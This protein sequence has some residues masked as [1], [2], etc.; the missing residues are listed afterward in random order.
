MTPQTSVPDIDQ[1]RMAVGELEKN[2]VVLAGAG[3]GK[4]TLL[5]DRL[6]LLL[7]GKE[8]PIEK[9][10]ALTFTKKAAEEMRE[11]LE[12]RLRDIIKGE[13]DIEML[14][15][16]FLSN[17]SRWVPLAKKALEDI[18]KAQIGTIHSFAGHVLRLYPLQ[19]GVD[20]K[21]R[22]DEGLIREITFESLWKE[23]INKELDGT[24]P[25]SVEWSVLLQRVLLSDLRKLAAALVSPMIDREDLKKKV[26]LT[27]LLNHAANDLVNLRQIYPD[28]VRARS[29]LPA[30]EALGAIFDLAKEKKPIPEAL[31]DLIE[32]VDKPPVA[33]VEA[34]VKLKELKRTAQAL[35][36]LDENLFRQIYER[37]NPFIER[38]Q[39]ELARGGAVSFDGL[40]V[41][42]RN[43]LREHREVRASLKKRFS[44]F[45]VDEF[46]DTDPLQGEILFYLAEGPGKQASCWQEVQLEPGRL[47]VVGDPKQ[48]IYRFRG[49]DIAA[50]EAFEEHMVRQGALQAT[51]SA[52]FRSA[53]PIIDFV[54]TVFSPSMREEKFIQPAYTPLEPGRM[55][56]GED[57]EF[58]GPA[59]T[60]VKV[61]G[62]E[63]EKLSA[64]GR[65]IVEAQTI[66]D[67]IESHIK[68][69][70]HYGDIAILLRSANAFEEY[71]EVF[72]SRGIPY[73]AEGEKSFYRT[74]E[75]LD[76]LN[77]LS[78]VADPNDKLALVGV[79]RSPVGGLN[80]KEIWDLNQAESLSVLKNPLVHQDKIG[81]LFQTLRELHEESKS[82]PLGRT[83][84]QIFSRTWALETASTS[85]HGEQAMA[86]L[87]KVG[88]LAEKWSEQTPLTLKEFVRRFDQYRDEER[89]EGENPL[90]DVKYDA[91]KVLTI[92]K[93][94]GLEFPLV[95]LPNLSANKRA[96]NDKKDVRRDWRTGTVGL[97]L[98]GAGF[99]NA[100]MIEIERQEDKRE[101][102]EEIRVFYV[103]TTRAKKQLVCFVGGGEKESGQFA[104]ILKSAEL[105]PHFHVEEIQQKPMSEMTS[106]RSALKL[107]N[108][109]NV[110]GLSAG[111]QKRADELTRLVNERLILSPTALLEEPEKKKYLEEDETYPAREKALL[112]GQI[113][114]KVLEEWDF[115]IPPAKHKALLKKNVDRAAQLVEFP[116]GNSSSDLIKNECAEIIGGFL[117]SALYQKLCRVK[118]IGRE[119]P[120]VY[121]QG[122]GLMRGVIDLLY[123]FEGLLVVADYKTNKLDGSST[124]Q[125]ETHYRPQGAA[126]Q[127]AV[128]RSLQREVVFELIFLR[129]FTAIRL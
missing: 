106:A 38:V 48:S 8:I 91:V 61:M 36:V 2:L 71:L 63:N 18:P 104:N 20:P 65:R 67:W 78:V 110:Q 60:V 68:N 89:D 87:L 57:A 16:K 76:F 86:N 23:W 49:A 32:P 1:R 70:L 62:S 109:W 50:F 103:A 116:M 5:I 26:D 108:T 111:F 33:W 123:E 82:H 15:E 93:A 121:P 31:L 98:E 30:L 115:Q 59:V 40:L 6:T 128:R 58:S 73:L 52:N 19:A 44:V 29:F 37:L 72:R 4:T 46:Q 22:E 120:F 77:L 54:N 45:L 3:T 122:S 53:P 7:I 34:K 83:L 99:T 112:I 74:S 118:I 25:S 113:C 90:A 24:K 95:I 39:R 114:H 119:M 42:A 27:S 41:F 117:K 51:L 43:L 64:K 21:F 127:E 17:R 124:L 35:A 55:V 80:D 107:D 126:Y 100:A 12:K 9:I 97:R 10:V 102:A 88:H 101:S 84:R 13:P 56:F 14:K 81:R 79:L 125:W 66:A 47:F 92:H 96:R 28:P 75:V 69:G 11:R 94:K 85:F 105:S 129:N